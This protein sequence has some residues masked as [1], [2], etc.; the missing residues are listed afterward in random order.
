MHKIRLRF[1]IFITVLSLSIYVPMQLLINHYS[2]PTIGERLPHIALALSKDNDIDLDNIRFEGAKIIIYATEPLRNVKSIAKIMGKDA[3]IIN[4]K[5]PPFSMRDLRYAK[6][7]WGLSIETCGCGNFDFSD[8]IYL[9]KIF[10]L[11]LSGM[12]ADELMTIPDMPRVRILVLR[13]N[14]GVIILPKSFRNKFQNLE[15]IRL[16]GYEI[17]GFK[18][19]PDG[20]ACVEQALQEL[21]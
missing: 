19:F 15:E 17:E 18:Y 14:N 10:Y 12:S 21:Q 8:L 3:E 13:N 20:S 9:K 11:K 16:E 1:I 6:N 2:H 4:L 5:S 7:L